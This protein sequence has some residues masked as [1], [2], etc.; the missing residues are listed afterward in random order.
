MFSNQFKLHVAQ[1]ISY[2]LPSTMSLFILSKL[3]LP[4]M[5]HGIPFLWKKGLYKD[6]VTEG[7]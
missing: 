7:N 2:N 4:R 3:I 6:K 1:L 5:V